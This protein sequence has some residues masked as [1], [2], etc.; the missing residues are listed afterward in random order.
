M[1]KL[2]FCLFLLFSLSAYSQK[3]DEVNVKTAGSLGELLTEAQQDTC[4]FLIVSGKLNSADIK[5][6]RRMAGA[7]GRGRL[8]GLNLLG[9]RIVSSEMPYLTIQKAENTVKAKVSTER[10]TSFFISP[11]D[12]RIASTYYYKYPW[13]DHIWGDFANFVLL[14]K[15]NER[16]DAQT[17]AENL[18]QWKKMKRQRLNAKGHCISKGDD[19]HYI[20]SAYTHKDLFCADMFYG[21]P[22]LQM[23]ILPR[24]GKIFD[25]VVID[26]DPI[27]YKQLKKAST[28]E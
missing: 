17:V 7:D 18:S 11:S 4:R 8:C 15:T 25:R 19:G 9:A 16:P 28:K 23:V 10:L 13:D 26:G 3:A 1:K 20:Y 5:V 27:C 24:K 2:V 14:P 21:C 6:L 22:N 12:S